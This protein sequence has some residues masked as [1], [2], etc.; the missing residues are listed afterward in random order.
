Q[1]VAEIIEGAE[2]GEE[3]TD[4]LASIT[5]VL[6]QAL[7]ENREEL[8]WLSEDVDVVDVR[9]A[10]VEDA[11]QILMEDWEGEG[12]APEPALQPALEETGRPD[13]EPQ[14]SESVDGNLMEL[15]SEVEGL[16]TIIRDVSRL[17]EHVDRQYQQYHKDV[18]DLRVDL[19]NNIDILEK[20]MGVLRDRMSVL[21]DTQRATLAEIAELP[22]KDVELLEERLRELIEEL[23]E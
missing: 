10:A 8:L 18:G 1:Q 20:M 22:Q 6:E 3:T 12:T 19:T 13:V 23:P 11:V 9:L 4:P 14:V 2:A 5:A 21:E 16:R 17:V 15:G 7:E